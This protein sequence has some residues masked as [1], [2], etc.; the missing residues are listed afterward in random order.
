MMSFKKVDIFYGINRKTF[1]WIGGKVLNV[2]IA[3]AN[4][5]PEWP[6]KYTIQRAFNK[7]LQEKNTRIPS[8]PLVENG[9][10]LTSFS[11]L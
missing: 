9:A 11:L 8:H 7:V 2:T 4:E 3:L 10:H 6:V 1:E 5:H